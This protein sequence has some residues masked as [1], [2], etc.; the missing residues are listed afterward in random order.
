M[1]NVS[2]NI[3][4]QINLSSGLQEKHD[5]SVVTLKG[6]LPIRAE[7]KDGDVFYLGN[8]SV[9]AMDIEAYLLGRAKSLRLYDE[10]DRELSDKDEAKLYQDIQGD[11]LEKLEQDIVSGEY[12][13]EIIQK[14][15]P[16]NGTKVKVTGADV[17]AGIH[18]ASPKNQVRTGGNWYTQKHADLTKEHTV[19]TP[20]FRVLLPNGQPLPGTYNHCG[21]CAADLKDDR[22]HYGGVR[23]CLLGISQT[24]QGYSFVF[25]EPNSQEVREWIIEN[26]EKREAGR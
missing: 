12:D 9:D 24:H 26:L 2:I 16:K 22:V 1:A 14:Y 7:V 20:P 18:R 3:K 8:Q 4:V 13:E 19:T 5:Y 25:L 21:H 10:N 6:R 23:A 17:K 11:I 15:N